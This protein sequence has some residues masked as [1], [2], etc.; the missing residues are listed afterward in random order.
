[1]P[2]QA[3]LQQKLQYQLY[4]PSKEELKAQI[5][6]ITTSLEGPSDESWNLF[7]AASRLR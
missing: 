4:L 7:R 6:S 3:K 1:V 5:E 2:K